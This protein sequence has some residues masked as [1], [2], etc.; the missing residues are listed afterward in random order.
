M[1]IWEKDSHKV[2]FLKDKFIFSSHEQLIIMIIMNVIQQIVYHRWETGNGETYYQ[3]KDPLTPNWV[4]WVLVDSKICTDT[5]VIIFENIALV[6]Y[7]VSWFTTII[8]CGNSN[9]VLAVFMRSSETLIYKHYEIG[10]IFYKN[11]ALLLIQ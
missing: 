9:F 10:L 2:T 1:H 5:T 6:F 8:A 7:L 3:W 11:S 4:F